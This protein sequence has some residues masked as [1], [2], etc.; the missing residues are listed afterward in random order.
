ME[1]GKSF[2]KNHYATVVLTFRGQGVDLSYKNIAPPAG[3]LAVVA[4]Q[5]E[6][7]VLVH[8]R[9]HDIY[10][11]LIEIVMTPTSRQ[12]HASSRIQ[13]AELLLSYG[14]GKP[15]QTTVVDATHTVNVNNGNPQDAAQLAERAERAAG[16]LRQLAAA[17]GGVDNERTVVDAQLVDK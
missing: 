2:H 4:A 9:V 15:L 14:L 12:N 10:N 3:S 13:A 11:V 17:Q 6:F 16:M 5:D 7:R 8:E 1:T